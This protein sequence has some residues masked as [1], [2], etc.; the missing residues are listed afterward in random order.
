M[1]LQRVQMLAETIYRDFNC[2]SHGVQQ[3][4]VGILMGRV[5]KEFGCPLCNKEKRDDDAART[6]EKDEAERQAKLERRMHA[7]GIPLAFRSRSFDGYQTDSKPM[8]DALR[9]MRS[10]ADDFW[11]EHIN[12]GTFMVLG[13]ERGTGKSHL[14]IAAAQQVMQRGTA[15]YARAADLI[16]RVRSTW[17]RDSD[18]SEEE[19]L[20]LLS[21][22]IDLLVIDE[23]GMQRGTEDEQIIL[24]DILDRRYA[25]LRPTILLT[26]LEGKEFAEFLGPRIM[27]RLRE[28]A[29]FVPFKWESYRGRANQ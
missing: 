23:V 13:G 15:M 29:V 18:Q 26:N 16:R 17:R 5:V 7:A 11:I 3:E 25:D 27:D 4:T 28:R 21:T 9:A 2:P 14:A 10:F 19:V 22:G 12:A 1:S 24:F 6:R 20:A 8:E